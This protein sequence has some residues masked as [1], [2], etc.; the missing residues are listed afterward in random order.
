MCTCSPQ[1]NTGQVGSTPFLDLNVE[2][3]WM[4]GITGEGV[5]VSFVDDGMLSTYMY[6]ATMIIVE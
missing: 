2:R 5:I 4:Q 1:L 3:A 6:V